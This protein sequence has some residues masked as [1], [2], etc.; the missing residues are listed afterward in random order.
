MGCPWLPRVRWWV[1]L[2][3]LLGLSSLAEAQQ[4]QKSDAELARAGPLLFMAAH[5]EKPRLSVASLARSW[6]INQALLV[7]VCIRSAPGP[8]PRSG[9]NRWLA[10]DPI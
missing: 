4:A 7:R 6:I 5:G 3:L 1:T 10:T 8:C 9:A 2:G